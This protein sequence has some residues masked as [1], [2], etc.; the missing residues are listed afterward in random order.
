MKKTFRNEVKVSEWAFDRIKD[1]FEQV[2]KDEARKLSIFQK[3]LIRS[4]DYLRRIIA[5]AG[6]HGG[7]TMSYL[8]RIATVSRWETTFGGSLVGKGVTIGGAR[9]VEK[10]IDWE[11]PNRLLVVQTGDSVNQAKVFR[12]HAVP[13]S[14]CGIL[15]NVLKLLANQQED[16]NGLTQN[17]VANL[18]EEQEGPHERI[19]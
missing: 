9:F 8:C 1:V 10:K 11:Q 6:E 5:P 13:Q 15:V 2:A 12:T 19:A 18:G 17:I 7:V 3:I 16:G 4:T 14:L